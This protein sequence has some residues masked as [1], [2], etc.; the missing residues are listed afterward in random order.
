MEE[1]KKAIAFLFKRKGRDSMLEKDFVMSASMDLGW[2]PPREAQRLMQLG[3]DSKLL[4]ASDGKLRPAF[5]ISVIDVPLDYT[6]PSTLLQAAVVS[7]NMFARIL[8]RIAA[9][10]K[11]E[12]RQVVSMINSAQDK[13]DVEAEVAA[14]IVGMDMGIDISDLLE[15]TEKEIISRLG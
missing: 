15:D 3:L 7:P 10:T 5:D 11:L 14:L 6:P 13:L 9:E 4:Q 1:V 12:R 8:E 2:F